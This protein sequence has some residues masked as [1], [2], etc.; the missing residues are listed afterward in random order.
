MLNCLWQEPR[1]R[2]RVMGKEETLVLG[3]GVFQVSIGSG[4]RDLGEVRD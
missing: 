3:L 4:V 1:S 2:N